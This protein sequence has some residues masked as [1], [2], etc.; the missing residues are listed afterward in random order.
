MKT[1]GILIFCG[2]LGFA[3]YITAT[4]QNLAAKTTNNLT[5]IKNR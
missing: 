1:F 2:F 5:F 4:G 3:T